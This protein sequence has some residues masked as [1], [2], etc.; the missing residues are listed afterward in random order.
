MVDDRAGDAY[1]GCDAVRAFRLMMCNIAR[2]LDTRVAP[3]GALGAVAGHLTGV[4]TDARSLDE[5][6]RTPINTQHTTIDCST[7]SACRK[8]TRE[9]TRPRELRRWAS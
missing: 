2:D 3:Y 5:R 8:M 4:L 1:R 6:S 7:V 9:M